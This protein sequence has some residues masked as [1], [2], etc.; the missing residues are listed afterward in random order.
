MLTGAWGRL[1]RRGFCWALAG[2]V[3]AFVLALVASAAS[4]PAAAKR[5]ASPKEG[6]AGALDDLPRREGAVGADGGRCQRRRQARHAHRQLRFRHR[7]VAARTWW[8]A[9][10]RPP[11]T[12]ARVARPRWSRWRT[13]TTTVRSISRRP[14]T[15]TAS[16]CCWQT[17]TAA[18]PRR[19]A[20]ARVATRGCVTA[21]DLNGDGKLDLISTDVRYHS[22]CLL[23][24][25]GDGRFP[26]PR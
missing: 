19:C 2:C 7:L 11:R 13:S 1:T 21:G 20:T 17:A 5:G 15:T 26:R 4:A 10:S 24:G 23:P 25:R 12:S 14:T 3:L 6:R 22:I 18:T 9:P 8:R 16:T